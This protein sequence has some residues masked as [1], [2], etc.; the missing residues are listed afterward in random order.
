MDFSIV[1]FFF[2]INTEEDVGFYTQD[3]NLPKA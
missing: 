2:L 3:E 1:L